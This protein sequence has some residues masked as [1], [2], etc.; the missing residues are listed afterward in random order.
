[1]KRVIICLPKQDEKS[2]GAVVLHE[3][4][5]LLEMVTTVWP[6][7][8]VPCP[9]PGG[10]HGWTLAPKTISAD[11]FK[12][13][14]MEDV[15]TIYPESVFGNPLGARNVIR[16]MLNKPNL[17]CDTEID[18]ENES[19]YSYM[20]CFAEGYPSLRIV[21]MPSLP[22]SIT[23]KTIPV[24]YLFKKAPKYHK[25]KPFICS[26]WVCIDGLCFER[27]LNVLAQCRFFI[28]FD[29]HTML[30]TFASALGAKSYVP[31]VEGFRSEDL[32]GVGPL[33]FAY[34]HYTNVDF[35]SMR[36]IAELSIQNWIVQS[37]KDF[38]N[39]VRDELEI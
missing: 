25:T 24:A 5:R 10:Q 20:S 34:G 9:V 22:Q 14:N 30:S 2:G 35:S 8:L 1:M 37:N 4:S 16:W 33:P 19:I 12:L 18:F 17:I 23:A 3:L 38:A 26:S 27:Q 15:V 13:A 39:F 11:I 28:S 29:P 36:Q 6:V 7:E 32:Y 31:A 21:S